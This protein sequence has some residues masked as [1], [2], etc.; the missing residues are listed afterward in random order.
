[1]ERVIRKVA[2]RTRLESRS[3]PSDGGG[4]SDYTARYGGIRA[5]DEDAITLRSHLI[6]HIG[7]EDV[8]AGQS[9]ME[10]I[11]SMLDVRHLLDMPLVT[12]SNGQTRRAR[13]ARALLSKPEMLVL[14]EPFSEST[15]LAWGSR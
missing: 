1:M 7:R 11:A 10:N 9:D 6:E 2:F 3:A 15:I 5:G 4:F 14:E 12:L 13:I 8:N